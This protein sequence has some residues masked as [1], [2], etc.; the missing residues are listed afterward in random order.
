MSG[1]NGKAAENMSRAGSVFIDPMTKSPQTGYENE[2]LKHLENSI[3]MFVPILLNPRRKYACT[4]ENDDTLNE[5]NARELVVTSPNAGK[6]VSSVMVQLI[7]MGELSSALYAAGAVSY[8]YTHDGISTVSLNR[9]YLNETILILAMG[10]S[11]AANEVMLDHFQN[12]S[13][14]R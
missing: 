2:C 4:L 12:T 13:Y 8:L 9:A 10:D 1:D 5:R 7:E 3:S 11:I 14:L 6:F